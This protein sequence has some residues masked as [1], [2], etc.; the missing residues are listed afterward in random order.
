M[1]SFKS[2]TVLKLILKFSY[3]EIRYLNCSYKFKWRNE[4]HHVLNL[5]EIYIFAVDDF[6][7]KSSAVPKFYFKLSYFETQFFI[8][9]CFNELR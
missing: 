5:N 1:T 6:H 4:H 2:F 9:N 7:F 3:F 8:S